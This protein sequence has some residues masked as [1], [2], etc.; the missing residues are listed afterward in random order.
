MIV[1]IIFIYIF[2]CNW[3]E[4]VL[5]VNE[6]VNGDIFKEYGI[7]FRVFWGDNLWIIWLDV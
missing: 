4:F 3:I 2:I 5:N 7:I 1:F 6:E